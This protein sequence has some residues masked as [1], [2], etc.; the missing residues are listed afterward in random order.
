LQTKATELLLAA[1]KTAR[2]LTLYCPC[3]TEMQAVSAV[4]LLELDRLKVGLI[5]LR[6]TLQIPPSEHQAYTSS[7]ENAF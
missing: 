7:M 4:M 1:K 5:I 3:G 6:H 2:H